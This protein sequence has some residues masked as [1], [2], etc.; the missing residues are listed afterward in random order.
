MNTGTNMHPDRRL[1]E[2][3]RDQTAACPLGSAGLKTPTPLRT[4]VERDIGQRSQS[5]TRAA[6]VEVRVFRKEAR[7]AASRY[8]QRQVRVFRKVAYHNAQNLR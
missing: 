1:C 3:I 4:A 5:N 6:I 2:W 8:G 7:T